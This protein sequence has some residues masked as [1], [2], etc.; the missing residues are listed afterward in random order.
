MGV[1]HA[2]GGAGTAGGI[3]NIGRI[4]LGCLGERVRRKAPHLRNITLI[5][6]R[7]GTG[8]WFQSVIQNNCKYFAE[9]IEDAIHL[10]L[11]QLR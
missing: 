3:D 11:C 6:D 9:I 8:R 2:L 10:R 7:N 5:D 4:I 1:Y